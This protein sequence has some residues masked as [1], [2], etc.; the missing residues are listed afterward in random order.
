[1]GMEPEKPDQASVDSSQVGAVTVRF[2]AAVGAVARAAG[3]PGV[4]YSQ[5]QRDDGGVIAALAIVAA[6]SAPPS[7]F[8]L[9]LH[10]DAVAVV[11]MVLP[12]VPAAPSNSRRAAPAES[13]LPSATATFWRAYAG[14]V[15]IRLGFTA[16][17]LLLAAAAP[18]VGPLL[19]LGAVIGEPFVV[20]AFVTFDYQEDGRHSDYWATWAGAFIATLLGTAVAATVVVSN[21]VPGSCWAPGHEAN[22]PLVVGGVLASVLASGFGAPLGA[23]ASVAPPPQMAPPAP[24]FSRLA[25]E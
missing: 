8:G 23:S 21:Y 24:P 11:P 22:V 14:D 13:L 3:S 18:F 19:A 25:F 12:A 2:T 1:M 17:E 15:G 7:Y 10:L 16:I 5:G 20:A 4:A 9:S 6:F